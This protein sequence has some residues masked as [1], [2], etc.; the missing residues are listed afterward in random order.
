MVSEFRAFVGKYPRFDA[1][2]ARKLEAHFGSPEIS[3][4]L[5]R[6]KD[7]A[8]KAARWS[9]ALG[10]ATFVAIAA[11]AFP[12]FGDDPGAALF[13]LAASGAGGGLVYALTALAFSVSAPEKSSIFEPLAKAVSKTFS[14]SPTPALFK[15]N[16]DEFVSLGLLSEYDRVSKSEDSVSYRF[17]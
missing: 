9:K 14:Y 3:A 8:E 7:S 4:V 13:A 6:L 2:D 16:T 15:G 12:A 17:E 11:F 5:L 10:L 1:E